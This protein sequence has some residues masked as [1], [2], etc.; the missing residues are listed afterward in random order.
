MAEKEFPMFMKCRS[1]S[2]RALLLVFGLIFVPSAVFAQGD[3]GTITGT[4]SDP[5]GAVVPNAP[6]KARHTETGTTY[7]AATSSTGNYTLSQLPAGTYSVTVAVPGFKTAV[8]Q[9]L[10]VE[11]AQTLRID[12]ALEVGSTQESVTVTAEAP[13]LKTESGELSHNVTVE[14]LDT[15]PILGIGAAAAGSSGIRNPTEVAV[16]IP[17]TFVQAN[18]NIRVNGA[19]GN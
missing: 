13:L 17:G 10:T 7:D 18:S 14:T 12:F 3:R 16:L 11:V 4:V 8:R 19:P 15:L 1:F 2:A 5:A 6:V 9:G